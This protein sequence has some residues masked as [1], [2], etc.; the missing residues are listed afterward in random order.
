VDVAEVVAGPVVANAQ[1]EKGLARAGRGGLV[2]RERALRPERR[3]TGHVVDPREDGELLDDR[4]VLPRPE[5]AGRIA[6]GDLDGTGWTPHWR[7]RVV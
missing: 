1:V 6:P 4:E 2:G 3:Q 7:E 5:E